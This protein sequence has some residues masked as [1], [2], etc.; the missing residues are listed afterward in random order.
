MCHKAFLILFHS[1]T[2][3]LFSQE[4]TFALKH[5]LHCGEKYFVLKGGNDFTQADFIVMS[6]NFNFSALYVKNISGNRH[7]HTINI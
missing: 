6:I 3:R 4:F 1:H 5:T 2:T 7:K